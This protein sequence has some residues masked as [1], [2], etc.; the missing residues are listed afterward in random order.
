M[1]RKLLKNVLLILA[2]LAIR[3]HG[4]KFIVVCGWH[5]T[6]LVREEIYNY[7]GEDFNVRRNIQDIW[8]D[9]SLP[10][11]ILG[12]KDR[13]YTTKYWFKIIFRTIGALLTAPNNPHKIII[14]LNFS[15]KNTSRY[16]K[17]M[18]KPETLVILNYK[19]SEKE[20]FDVLID[21]TEKNRGQVF[22]AE[23]LGKKFAKYKK[24]SVDRDF[25]HTPS[26]K[27][28]YN[29]R[30]PKVFVESYPAV[31]AVLERYGWNKD[32]IKKTITTYNMTEELITR[33]RSNIIKAKFK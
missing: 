8:W 26:N 33:I 10:L 4:I 2:K 22:V 3:K 7:L 12:Y 6:K 30:L 29:P 27:F 14:D 15:D 23:G 11:N 9:L 20:L 16:W 13:R 18:I 28:K 1:Y 31:L 21:S 32:R 24:F 19:Q 25:I 17:R 5:R